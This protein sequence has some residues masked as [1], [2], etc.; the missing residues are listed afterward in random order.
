MGSMD[1]EVPPQI[2][3]ELALGATAR[4]WQFLRPELEISGASPR[5]IASLR[6]ALTAA[7][8]MNLN[9]L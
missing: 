9:N 2:I 5:N 3:L 4:R 8:L 7:P 6:D 1:G